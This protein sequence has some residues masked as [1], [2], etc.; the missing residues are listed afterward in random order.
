M[1]RDS[2][3]FIITL[4]PYW[5]RVPPHDQRLRDRPAWHSS[6]VR[7]AD[8]YW[9]SSTWGQYIP[10]TQEKCL[11]SYNDAVKTH[12]MHWIMVL[13]SLVGFDVE[14]LNYIAILYHTAQ[15]LGRR[16]LITCCLGASHS[17]VYKTTLLFSET[18]CF[19]STSAACCKNV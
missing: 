2:P 14:E 6:L 10:V 4:N 13:C 5:L 11:A 15:C 18:F 7:Q 17:L 12:T 3:V 8:A 9:L 1:G 16:Y 19:F